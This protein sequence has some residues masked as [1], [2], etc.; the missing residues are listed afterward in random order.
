MNISKAELI[1]RKNVLWN[2]VAGIINAAEA[3]IIVAVVSRVNG[4]K[5][6]EF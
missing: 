5:M 3:V 4:L 2:V 6:P 1:Y